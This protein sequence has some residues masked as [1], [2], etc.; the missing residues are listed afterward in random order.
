[1]AKKTMVVVE[2]NGKGE[3]RSVGI[4]T[5]FPY[6]FPGL[7]GAELMVAPGGAC[8]PSQGQ[9]KSRLVPFRHAAAC[10]I[11]TVADAGADIVFAAGQ[12]VVLFANGNEG[13]TTG[14]TTGTLTNADTNAENDG[15]VAKG[16]SNFIAEGI[17]VAPMEP[18]LAQ[19]GKDPNDDVGLPHWLRDLDADYGSAAMRAMFDAVSVELTNGD[20]SCV[21]DMGPMALWAQMSGVGKVRNG[22]GGIGGSLWFMATPQVS[23]SAKSS[24]ELTVTVTLQK[25]ITIPSS[26]LAPTAAGQVVLPFRYVLLGYPQCPTSA[27]DNAMARK[28]IEQDQRMAELEKRLEAAGK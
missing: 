4:D 21:Y 27:M 3:I 28:I 24:E 9:L 22:I 10:F 20:D 5:S 18:W 25:S 14:L 23:A 8:D 13:A 2:E 12:S 19:V 26:A 11:G 7:Q 15:G 1:M 16:S 17:G 6:P